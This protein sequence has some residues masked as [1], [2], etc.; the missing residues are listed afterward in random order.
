MLLASRALPAESRAASVCPVQRRLQI[1]RR[2]SPSSLPPQTSASLPSISLHYGQCGKSHCT[3]SAGRWGM[4]TSDISR[5]EDE[6]RGPSW[7]LGRRRSAPPV[8]LEQE[9]GQGK[10]KYS[11]RLLLWL[12]LRKAFLFQRST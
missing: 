12:C 9:V 3:R 6:E 2:S 1:P 7:F 11:K 10:K 4:C 5:G 8:K